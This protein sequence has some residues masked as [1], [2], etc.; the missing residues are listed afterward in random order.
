MGDGVLVKFGSAV[1]AVECAEAVQAGF[2]G[3][4]G[5][6]AGD[7]QIKLRIGI[8]LGDAIVEGAYLNG[9][10]VNIAARL[11]ALAEPGGICVSAL[12][13]D[14]VRGR[15]EFGFDAMGLQTLRNIAG[16]VQVY[17]IKASVPDPPSP[18]LPAKPSV[19]VLP[20][21]SKS[22][23]PEQELFV[24]GLTEDLIADLSRN[25]DLTVIAR[26]SA[27]ACKGRSETWCAARGG[28]HDGTRAGAG[29]EVSRIPILR[30]PSNTPVPP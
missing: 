27:F 21:A 6:V 16:P 2:S 20:F 9:D 29:H 18:A 17:R 28:R 30:W 25:A 23:D 8:N 12:V 4:N 15:V 5:G 14:Q 26:N 13:H 7:Q 1:D 10:G 22:A 11:E 24:D 3:A 19:A